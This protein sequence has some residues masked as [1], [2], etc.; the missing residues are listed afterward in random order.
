M[1]NIFGKYFW[2][3]STFFILSFSYC[4]GKDALDEN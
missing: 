4:D 3:E 1:K 2:G